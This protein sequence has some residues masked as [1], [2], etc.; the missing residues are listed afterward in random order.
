FG[1]FSGPVRV[2]TSGGVYRGGNPSQTTP[3]TDLTFFG[4]DA[5]AV[6]LYS[7]EVIDVEIGTSYPSTLPN[8]RFDTQY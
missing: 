5:N 7:Y 4:T 3:A 6:P 2:F 1:P 8:V